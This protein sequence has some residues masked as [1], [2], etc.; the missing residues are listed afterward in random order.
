M[1]NRVEM[2]KH[3]QVVEEAL[4]ILSMLCTYIVIIRFLDIWVAF[5][6]TFATIIG[7]YEYRH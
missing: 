1:T 2:K 5:L 3:K 4:L 7:V 6:I